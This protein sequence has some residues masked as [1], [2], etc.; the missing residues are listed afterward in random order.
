MASCRAIR[1]LSSTTRTSNLVLLI[2]SLTWVRNKHLEHGTTVVVNRN[3]AVQAP[4]PVL[5]DG[6]AE[7]VSVP[8]CGP[9]RREH[10]VDRGRRYPGAIVANR[11]A[12]PSVRAGCHPG[13]HPSAVGRRGVDGV[14]HQ[15]PYDVRQGAA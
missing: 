6:K 7:A 9:L 12:Q 8:L 2:F 10:L 1:S 3:P 15:V 4:Y 5:H 11:D 14:V 13:P